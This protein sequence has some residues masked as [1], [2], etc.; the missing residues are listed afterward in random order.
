MKAFLLE[1]LLTR[2]WR[3]GGEVFWTEDDATVAGNSM[4]RRGIARR[5]RIL[6]AEVALEPFAELPISPPPADGGE[7]RP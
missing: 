1:T 6:P 5:V 7:A 4:I 3:R 2:G